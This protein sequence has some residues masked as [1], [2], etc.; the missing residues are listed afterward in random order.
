[1]TLV[2]AKSSLYPVAR[3]SYA[4]LPQILGV[5]NLIEVQLQSFRW[6]QEEGL[7]H[8][9]EEVSPI[10][11]FTGNRLELTFVDY[12]FREPRHSEQECLQRD[13]TYSA[14]LYIKT[15]LL[16]KQTGEIKEQDLFL[17]EIPLM[18]ARGTFITSG[19]ERVVVSQLL[20]SPGVYFT[21]EEDTSSGLPLCHAKL[22]SN[23]GAWLEFDTSSAGVISTKINGK[24]KIQ[25]TTLL[26]AIGFSSD[27]ELLSMFAKE[28]NSPDRQFISIT[29]A[30]EPNIRDESEALIDIYLW[31]SKCPARNS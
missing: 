7:R 17:G 5:P 23:R 30:R 4:K 18:T 9:L 27:E 15:R 3:K 26:R 19:A 2:D 6:F 1:M 8:V 11:D 13:L 24:R 14:P 10:K 22:I 20:R 29:M 25:V 28:D 12:E 16:I 21:V 31:K